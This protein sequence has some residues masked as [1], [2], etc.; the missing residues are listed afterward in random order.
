[1]QRC[2]RYT[3]NELATLCIIN[4]DNNDKSRDLQQNEDECCECLN[5]QTFPSSSN[6]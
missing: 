2:T 3:N 1:M 5:V 6:P 4:D